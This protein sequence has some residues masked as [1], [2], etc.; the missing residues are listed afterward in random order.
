M[1]YISCN[2]QCGAT[3]ALLL[4]TLILIHAGSRFRAFPKG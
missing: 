4:F 1:L 2:S 3:T